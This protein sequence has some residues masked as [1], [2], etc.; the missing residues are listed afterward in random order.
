MKLSG[1]RTDSVF[2]RYNVVSEEDLTIAARLL[3]EAESKVKVSVK[4]GR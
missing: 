2:R 3:E 4:V 1:H